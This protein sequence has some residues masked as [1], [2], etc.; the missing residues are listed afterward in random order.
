MQK[1]DTINENAC[2]TGETE[3][4]TTQ[5]YLTN[6]D[7]A[8]LPQET[9]DVLVIGPLCQPGRPVRSPRRPRHPL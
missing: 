3:A 7:T 4:G 5:R 9:A 2:Q 6:F 1:S 8:T